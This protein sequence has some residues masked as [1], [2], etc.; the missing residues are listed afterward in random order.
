M[1]F[2]RNSL[3]KRKELLKKCK[4]TAFEKIEEQPE[5][6]SAPKGPTEASIAAFDE[7]EEAGFD[8]F[9]L[10]NEGHVG[11]VGEEESLGA[12]RQEGLGDG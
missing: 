10:F 4:R 8:V 9:A 6:H 5:N 2:F 3:Q 1:H 11:H 12:A 7:V